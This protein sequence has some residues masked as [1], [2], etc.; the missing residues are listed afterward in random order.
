MPSYVAVILG[1]VLAIIATVA[2]CIFIMPENKTKTLNKFLYFVHKLI[3][4]KFLLIEKILK[5]LYVFSTASVILIGFFLLFSVKENY[6]ASILGAYSSSHWMGGY[7]LALMI[8]G[9][10]VIRLVYESLMMFILLVNNTIA[11]K[12][13][14]YGDADEKKEDSGSSVKPNYVFCRDCGTRYDE[15]A[16]GCPNCQKDEKSDSDQ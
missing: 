11:I 4:F 7:G 9:P 8:V 13:K 5:I 10:I 3:N 1:V 15:N 16:G 12:N 14:L 2:A 6:I